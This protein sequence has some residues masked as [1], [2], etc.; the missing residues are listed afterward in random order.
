[1]TQHSDDPRFHSGSYSTQKA[2]ELKQMLKG[3]H[4]KSL[5]TNQN[6]KEFSNLATPMEPVTEDASS[7]LLFFQ[8][9]INSDHTQ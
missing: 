5:K 8:P 1:M 6:A 3:E 2:E 4:D 7:E 9:K